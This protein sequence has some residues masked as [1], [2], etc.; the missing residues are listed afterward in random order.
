MSWTM[1]TLHFYCP[2]VA[3][4]PTYAVP[5]PRSERNVAVRVST[6]TVFGKEAFWVELL[7]VGEVLWFPVSNGR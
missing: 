2:L 7:R 6:H 3:V 4:L 5:G 1:A